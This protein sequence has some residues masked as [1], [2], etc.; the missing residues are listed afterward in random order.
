MASAQPQ[1]FDSVSYRNTLI[2]QYRSQRCHSTLGAQQSTSQATG[3]K[4]AAGLPPVFTTLASGNGEVPTLRMVN[5]Q[6][7]LTHLSCITPVSE[8]HFLHVMNRWIA[9]PHLIIPPVE[10]AVIVQQDGYPVDD[11]QVL[12]RA[13]TVQLPVRHARVVRKLLPKRAAKDAVITETVEVWQYGNEEWRVHFTP[14]LATFDGDLAKLPFYYPKFAS[15]AYVYRRL[16]AE[17]KEAAQSEFESEESEEIPPPQGRLSV[18]FQLLRPDVGLFTLTAKERSSWPTILTKLAKWC[19]SELTGYQ[20]TTRYD[21]LVD[22]DRYRTIRAALKAR[23]AAPWIAQ[24]PEKTDASKFIPEDI[25]I[26]AWLLGIWQAE[27]TTNPFRHKY[28]DFGCGN[29][30]L[31]HLLACEGIAGYGIDQSERK[32]WGYYATADAIDSPVRYTTDLRAE[33]LVPVDARY[34]DVEWF[35]GNHADEL[36]PWIP[37]MAARSRYDAKIVLIPCC[38]FELSG[39]KFVAPKRRGEGGDSGAGGTT[40]VANPGV[41]RFQAYVEYIK[42][43]MA[44]CGF[45]VEHET[46]RIPSTKDIALVGRR[47]T[48]ARDDHEAEQKVLQAIDQ[49][50]KDAGRFVPPS[51]DEIGTNTHHPSASGHSSP[52]TAFLT[53]PR[54]RAARTVSGSSGPAYW[55]A[56]LSAAQRNGISALTEEGED[57]DNHGGRGDGAGYYGTGDRHRGR[58]GVD[59]LKGGGGGEGEPVDPQARLDWAAAETAGKIGQVVRGEFLVAA[60]DLRLIEEVNVTTREKYD[61]LASTVQDLLVS[62]AKAQ[63]TYSE[64]DAYID[65]AELVTQQIAELEEMA[66][67]LDAFSRQLDLK[68]QRLM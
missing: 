32:V 35:I 48:F 22:H 56:L 37:I 58:L 50:V 34:P 46:L 63:Q 57:D 36:I 42:E 29:G 4:L 5:D 44:V 54:E 1:P 17:Q 15:Y 51:V 18:E 14:D 7:W 68:F 41:T 65:Q 21:I 26:A 60:E 61:S 49:L 27:P 66:Q 53:Q 28:V 55:D 3:N 12:H 13:S 8:A 16:T 20:K 64:M 45:E 43:I 47:R 33:T 62:A 10:Q 59:G 9:E 67:Q 25:S 6:P 52:S 23:Y 31:V 40:A 38:P 24:W 2:R 30:F 11:E 19:I 39:A